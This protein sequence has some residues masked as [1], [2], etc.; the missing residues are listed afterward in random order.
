MV[1]NDT[2]LYLVILYLIAFIFDKLLQ[3]VNHIELFIIIIMTNI[4]RMQPTFC[5]HC[6]CCF[7]WSVQVT[8]SGNK[9]GLAQMVVA[10]LQAG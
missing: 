1:M 2:E 6:S 7:C 10:I 8:L 5:I 9:M 3:P 4:S